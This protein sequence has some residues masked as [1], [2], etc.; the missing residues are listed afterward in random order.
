MAFCIWYY[1]GL[2]LGTR[3]FSMKFYTTIKFVI[4]NL[5][6]YLSIRTTNNWDNMNTSFPSPCMLTINLFRDAKYLVS[7]FAPLVSSYSLRWYSNRGMASVMWVHGY[8]VILILQ[9]H[10]IHW[11]YLTHLVINYTSIKVKQEFKII[12]E[13]SHTFWHLQFSLYSAWVMIQI[14]RN[15]EAINDTRKNKV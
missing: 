11:V 12:G 3:H 9:N 8:W 10:Q 1:C 15:T 5:C 14:P 4:P 13:D 2:S 7:R 6:F